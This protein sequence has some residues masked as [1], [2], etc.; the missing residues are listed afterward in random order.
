[1]TG[2][3]NIY[4]LLWITGTYLFCGGNRVLARDG[5]THTELSIE[6]E[7]EKSDPFQIL[8]PK[9]DTKTLMRWKDVI[10]TRDIHYTKWRMEERT[11]LYT[12]KKHMHHTE[13]RS[14]KYT[15]MVPEKRTKIVQYATTQCLPE[16]PLQEYRVRIPFREEFEK[17]YT[18]MIPVRQERTTSWTVRVPYTE[19]FE[20]MYTVMIPVEERKTEERTIKI[21]FVEKIDETYT[22]RIPYQEKMT[23][24][25]KIIKRIPVKTTKIVTYRGGHWKIEAK[26]V[27]AN[28]QYDSAGNPYVPKTFFCRKWIPTSETREVPATMW[29]YIVEEVPY[30]TYVKKY[31]EEERSRTKY[32]CRYREE[33]R[34]CDYSVTKMV[35]EK[36]TKI[37]F[38]K[39]YRN[40]K[41]TGTYSVTKMVPEKRTK[42]VCATR[43]RWETRTREQTLQASIPTLQTKEIG[44]TVMVPKEKICTYSVLVHD[45]LTDQKTERYHVPVPYSVSKQV[46]ITVRRCIVEQARNGTTSQSGEIHSGDPKH[47]KKAA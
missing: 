46:P 4:L 43:Y 26:E 10:E 18:V 19:T 27:A 5:S 41:R 31:R 45:T 11:H 2:T 39:K 3:Q 37:V 17:Q 7:Q 12:T 25:R 24:Y 6:H 30:I 38:V 15:I 29:K 23:A 34:F 8:P 35:P 33:K 1:V 20:K 22:V 44:Y 16:S 47:V 28:K 9:N 21:P 36:R 13:Q 32:I 40:E 42:L 14:K